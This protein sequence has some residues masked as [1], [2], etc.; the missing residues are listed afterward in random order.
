MSKILRI[1]LCGAVFLIFSN[2]SAAVT[3][4]SI[5]IVPPIQFPP[6]NFT[7]AGARV[8]ALWGQH[9]HVYGLDIGV[10]GNITTQDFGG[11]AVSGIFNRNYG[12]TTVVGL[13]L[14]G[15]A[16]I[17][18]QKTNVVGLQVASVNSNT[19]TSTVTGLQIGIVAN[20][21]SH[22]KV[23]GFQIGAYNA[24]DEVY[25]FQIGIINKANSLHGLQ[26]GLINFHE[27]GVFRVCP[28]LNFGF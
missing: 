3:P 27:K 16:N 5:S 21:S 24:A 23:Y 13:Q 15:I 18:T 17:N 1:L 12:T 7:V 19:G 2:V 20:L 6:Q 11:I 10:I 22:T 26:I 14:A 8:S 4:I 28:I 9:G 25:G